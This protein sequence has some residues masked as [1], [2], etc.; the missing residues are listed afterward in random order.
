MKLPSAPLD[1]TTRGVYVHIPF[2]LVRCP[3]CDFNAYAGMD[4][5]IPNYVEAIL[6]EIRGRA[7]GKRV[8]SV[9]FGGGTPTQIPAVE[10]VR[11]LGVIGDCF[12]LDPG[13]EITV[14]ANPETAGDEVFE[15]LLEGGF[16]RVSIGVQSLDGGVLRSLGRAH[17]RDRALEALRAAERAGFS[18]VNADLIFGTPGETADQWR[19]SLEGVLECG[20]DHVSCYALTIE[21][22]TPLARWV[23]QGTRRAPDEDD[24]AEKYEIA[25]V[26][27]NSEGFVGYEV[28]NWARPGGWSTHNLCYW[29]AGDYLGFGAGAHSHVAGRRFWNLKSPRAYISLAPRCE[30]GFEVLSARERAAEALFLGLRLAGGIDLDAFLGKFGIDPCIEWRA[31][32]DEIMDLGLAFV[33]GGYLRPRERGFLYGNEISRRFVA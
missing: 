23:E 15:T 20:V 25:R 33:S 19:R 6:G 16:N 2:C 31:E 27:L 26:I 18:R 13:A 7:D 4:D 30:E 22:G 9:F 1:D 14:E 8:S 10:L 11:I 21:Q 29:A 28:S 17:D 5:L 3:Y 12:T 32:I 24:Q